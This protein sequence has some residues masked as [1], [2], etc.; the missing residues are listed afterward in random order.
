VLCFAQS[1]NNSLPPCTTVLYLF[2]YLLPDWYPDKLPGQ[3]PGN[4]LP[5][6]GSPSCNALHC[7]QRGVKILVTLSK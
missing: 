3:Y 6:N 5:D 1:E 2:T 7:T 4:E